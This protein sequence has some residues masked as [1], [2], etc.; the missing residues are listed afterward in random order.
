MNLQ[1]LSRIV[2]IVFVS[3]SGSSQEGELPRVDSPQP[4]EQ[5]QG[6][7]I[8]AGNTAISGFSRAEVNFAFPEGNTWF[9]IQ[10]SDQPVRNGPIATWDTTTIVDGTYRLRVTV[11]LVDG[12]YAQVIVSDLRVANHVIEATRADPSSITP[13]IPQ[14]ERSEITPS[15]TGS[16]AT[17]F[18]ENPAEVSTTGLMTVM[19]VSCLGILFLFVIWFGIKRI[20]FKRD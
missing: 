16:T 6:E 20:F 8:I 11:F 17:A 2:T 1:I 10:S 4:G 15:I 18:P 13:T 3:L 19:L 9:L 5:V 14:M 7:V 12:S